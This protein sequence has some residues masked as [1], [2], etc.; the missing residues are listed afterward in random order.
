MEIILIQPLLFALQMPNDQYSGKEVS[1]GP[2]YLQRNR[3]P[4]LLLQKGF[5]ILKKATAACKTALQIL[6]LLQNCREPCSNLIE[7]L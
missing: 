7:T 4:F 6:S 5:C 3:L 1:A 2:E